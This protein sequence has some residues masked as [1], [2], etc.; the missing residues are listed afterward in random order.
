MTWL[1]EKWLK[2]VIETLNKQAT[3][4]EKENEEEWIKREGYVTEETI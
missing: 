1:S 2:A 3:E 4:E